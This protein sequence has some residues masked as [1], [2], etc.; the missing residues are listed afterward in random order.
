[1]SAPTLWP[2]NPPVPTRRIRRGKGS[3]NLLR[4]KQHMLLWM[5]QLEQQANPM[6]QTPLDVRPAEYD[7]IERNR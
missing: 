6:L 4:A 2:H 1:M 3:G 7:R 5:R